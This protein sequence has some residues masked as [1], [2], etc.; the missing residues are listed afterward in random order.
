MIRTREARKFVIR[1]GPELARPL[2]LRK[3][4]RTVAAA[5]AITAAL[6]LSTAAV[7]QPGGP[8]DA[9]GKSES[10]ATVLAI[11]STAAG[12]GLLALASHSHDD[13]DLTRA[14]DWGGLGLIVIG[15]SAGHIY[16]GEGLH[17][18]GFS[19]LRL[20]SLGAF[21]AGVISSLDICDGVVPCQN[22]SNPGANVLMAAGAIG[23][24]GLTIYD[25]HGASGAVRR[26]NAR[27]L[28]L[29]PAPLRTPGGRAAPGLVLA[30]TF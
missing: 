18:L 8:R 20:V 1:R 5:A 17:A 29:A 25:I 23:Y 2:H 26:A 30:G 4:M 27:A 10:T 22:G 16:A 3:T 7:A 9:P 13:G 12:F 19:A 28:T 6:S 11:G 14:L 15:P 21:V 24:V